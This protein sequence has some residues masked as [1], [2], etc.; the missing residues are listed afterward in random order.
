MGDV[1]AEG[2]AIHSL[3]YPTDFAVFKPRADVTLAG[4]AYAPG[5]ASPAAQVRFRFGRKGNGFDRSIAV[6]GERRW[7]QAVV[8]LAPTDARP[9]AGAR[10]TTGHSGVWKAA[11]GS[12]RGPALGGPTRP[13]PKRRRT[14]TGAPA[15]DGISTG[16]K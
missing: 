1:H 10:A 5:G 15:A 14:C 13:P 11:A 6:F 7:Q 16:T 8:R 2:D 9:P 12:G 3:L 4:H